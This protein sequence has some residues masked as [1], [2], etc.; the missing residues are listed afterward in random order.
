[1]RV[2]VGN[3]LFAVLVAATLAAGQAA[4]AANLVTPAGGGP[5]TAPLCRGTAAPMLPAAAM[6]PTEFSVFFANVYCCAPD[7]GFFCNVESAQVCRMDGGQP[8]SS[9][10]T[11]QSH[12]PGAG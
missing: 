10:A 12:C 3:A 11:C 5:D 4:A 8:Y 6:A 1:M 2:I 9:L 7:V